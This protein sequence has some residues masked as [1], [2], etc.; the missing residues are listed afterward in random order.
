MSA[1]GGGLLKQVD[2][3][4]ELTLKC[5]DK[6]QNGILDFGI[7]FSWREPGNDDTCIPNMIYPGAPSKCFCAR[8]DIPQ[9]TTNKNSTKP[10]YECL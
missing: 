7:C 5:D 9:V 1:G 4:K 3:A 6:N 2:I 10:E 8:Y